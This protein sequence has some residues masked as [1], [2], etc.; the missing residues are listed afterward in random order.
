MRACVRACVCV[1]DSIVIMFSLI[2]TRTHRHI[3]TRARVLPSSYVRSELLN[4]DTA[5][6]TSENFNR[7]YIYMSVYNNVVSLLAHFSAKYNLTDDYL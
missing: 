6:S 4:M 2:N 3:H 7:L 5:D 1:C